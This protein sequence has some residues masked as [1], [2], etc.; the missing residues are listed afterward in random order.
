MEIK[1]V[2]V[3]G[4][5][6]SIIASGYPMKTEIKAMPSVFEDIEK[7]IKRM[8]NLGSAK[9]NSGH[10]AAMKGIIVQ[11]DLTAPEYFWRQFDRYHYHDYISS[12]SKMHCIT[13]MN[14][15]EMCNDYVD[16]RII[17]ILKEY[18]N[19]Y[20]NYD[21]DTSL[22]LLYPKEYYFQKIVANCPMGLE[23]TARITS[24]YLQEKT[25]RNQ[26]KNHKIKEW[27]IYLKWQETLPMFLR[28]IGEK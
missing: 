8:E 23:L 25:I 10:D 19:K 6:E 1:N 24:N 15:D 26:R 27:A 20:N 3:Y 14:I 2:E 28:L 4:L 12:Q 22:Q 13:K 17:N 21:N 7:D 9:P 11:F 5:N 16:E 18:I